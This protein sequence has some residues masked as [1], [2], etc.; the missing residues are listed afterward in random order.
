MTDE[1]GRGNGGRTR[2]AAA[3]AAGLAVAVAAPA[4]A[5]ELPAADGRGLGLLAVV[6]LAVA[7]GLVAGLAVVALHVDVVPTA[8]HRLELLVGPAL[9]ALGLAAAV[10]LGGERPGLAAG[11]VAGGGLAAAVDARR[12]RGAGGRAGTALGAVALHRFVEGV[13]LAA[14][15]AA[16]V[17]VG[18]LGA[19]VLA[20]HVALET[21]CV[22]GLWARVD[23]RRAVV[24]V[25]LVQATFLAGTLAGLGATLALAGLETVALA[26]AS[27]GLLFVGLGEV[28]AHL[29]PAAPAESAGGA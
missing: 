10:E 19:V 6:G 14:A 24:A 3:L 1:S 2:I 13:A 12:H 7:A 22:G 26:A 15:F 29:G 27:A 20:S 4:S 8:T 17:V 28:G 25:V 23:R 11:A 21:A 16:D 5:H 18:L 9:V